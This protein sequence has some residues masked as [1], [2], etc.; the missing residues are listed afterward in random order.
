MNVCFRMTK[1]LSLLIVTQ[2]K[3]LLCNEEDK[4]KTNKQQ[5]YLQSYEESTEIRGTVRKLWHL[6][7]FTIS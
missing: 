2:K 1:H 5:R 6:K 3:V 4:N 7:Q